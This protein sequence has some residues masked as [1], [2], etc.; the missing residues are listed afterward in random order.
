MINLKKLPV[1]NAILSVVFSIACIFLSPVLQ[2]SYGEN[3]TNKQ[4]YAVIEKFEQISSIPRCSGQEKYIAKWIEKWA[5]KNNLEFKQDYKGNVLIKV[6]ATP[7]YKDAPVIVLQAHLDMVCENTP[8]SKHDFKKDGLELEYRGDWLTARGTTLGA[9]NGIGIAL[10]MA[11]T[12][13]TSVPHP[14]LELLF[15]VEEERG[16]KGAAELKSEFFNG[17]VFINIDAEREG[18]LITGSAGG[19]AT[20]ITLPAKTTKLPQEFVI[21]N[22]Q[23]SGLRGGHSGVDI[24]ENRGNAIKILAGAMG[25]LNKASPIR[26]VNLKGG[27]KA[28]AI[29]RDARASLALDPGGLDR[30]K[31]NIAAY[32][33]KIQSEY[34]SMEA[35]VSITLTATGEKKPPEAINHKDTHKIISLLNSL[36]NGVTAMSAEFEG[37][38]ETSNNIGLTYFK[39]NTFIVLNL[40]RSSSMKNLGALQARIKAAAKNSGAKAR[41]VDSWPTWEPNRASALL[42]RCKKVYSTRFGKNPEIKVIHGGLECSVI[43]AKNPGL[44]MIAIGPTIENAHSPGERLNIPSVGKLWKFLADLLGSY[45]Q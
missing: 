26:L 35:G 36:P 33:L 31:Q 3:I 27:S 13:D 42:Q 41:V 19:A 45:N 25:A 18:V 34:A 8:D 9:D 20:L 39:D 6:P 28:N 24:H 4:L 29:P 5:D 17:K 30:F 14:P 32:E 2:A 38:V 21:F 43:G 40:V 44:D 22:L 37:N 7:G 15:T 1:V 11:L 10:C 16:L 12:E 23:V